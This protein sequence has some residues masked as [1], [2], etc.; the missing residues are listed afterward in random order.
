MSKLGKSLQLRCVF[1][2][3]VCLFYLL[4]GHI[5]AQ[6]Q[7]THTVLKKTL[8]PWL[9]V[10]VR[11]E[12]KGGSWEAKRRTPFSL[13]LLTT[14]PLPAGSLWSAGIRPQVSLIREAGQA[15]LIPSGFKP[16]WR[17]SWKLSPGTLLSSA[18]LLQLPGFLGTNLPQKLVCE[19]AAGAHSARSVLETGRWF[20]RESSTCSFSSFW[21]TSLESFQVCPPLA[22]QI[23]ATTA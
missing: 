21:S 19:R 5:W 4:F 22:P 17:L 1:L 18:S 12:W 14:S 10:F 8:R 11:E 16:Q 13:P 23:P 6:V 9:R 20:S 15:L 7:S 2:N 3:F